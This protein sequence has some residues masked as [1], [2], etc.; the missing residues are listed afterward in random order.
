M[1]YFT[2]RCFTPYQT[3]GHRACTNNPAYCTRCKQAGCPDFLTARQRT[4]QSRT[5]ATVFQFPVHILRPNL[6]PA[7]HYQKPTRSTCHTQPER[8]RHYLLMPR[9]F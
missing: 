4:A 8:L 6:F 3:E 1:S 7:A 2:P 5:T 9:L